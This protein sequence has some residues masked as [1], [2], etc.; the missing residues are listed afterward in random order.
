MK[1]NLFASILFVLL[2]LTTQAQDVNIP[3]A[4]FLKALISSGV[5]TNNDGKIQVSEASV[6]TALNIE[7]KF[8]AS[9]NGIE[10]FTA[11]TDL[12]CSRNPLSTLNLSKNSALTNLA[13]S[14]NYLS[15][16]D[17]SKNAALI[18]LDCSLN[19]LNSLDL[20]KNT[21][22]ELDCSYNQL[23]SLDISKNTAL[24]KLYCNN[25]QLST[26]DVNNNTLKRLKCSQNQLST[27]DIS[28]C[29]ALTLLDCYSNKLST[30]DVSKNGSLN[31]LDC[32][33]NQL[34]TLDVS[35]N[36]F[37]ILFG[38]FN[39]Q[40]STL[41]IN[42]NTKL[43]AMY[44]YNNPLKCISFLPKSIYSIKKDASLCLPNLP[45]STF[46]L[47]DE[48]NNFQPK[49]LCTEAYNS[50][51]Q[52]TSYPNIS[53]RIYID[54]NNDKQY[55]LGTDYPMP[56]AS[57][58]SIS[59][60]NTDIF[61][62]YGFKVDNLNQTYTIQPALPDGWLSTPIS[63]TVSFKTMGEV[64]E[65]KDF[66]V[67][68]PVLNDVW[69]EASPVTFARPG[70]V[71]KYQVKVKNLGGTVQTSTVQLNYPAYFTFI[72]SI[73]AGNNINTTHTWSAANLLP[74]EERIFTIEFTLSAET[75]LGT[76][77][78]STANIS[79]P[80][81]GNLANNV[82]EIKQTVRGSYDPNDK[83]LNKGNTVLRSAIQAQE[84]FVY[85]IRFQNTGTDTAFRVIIRDTLALN[86]FDLKS[87]QS[88][89]SSHPYTLKYEGNFLNW[90][91]NDIL[92]PDSITDKVGSNGF[93]KF[94]I[95]PLSTLAV[96]EEINNKAAIY[97]DFNKAVI[98][99][100]VN[101]RVSL[102]NSLSDNTTPTTQIFPNPGNGLFTV[103][104]VNDAYIQVLTATG[105]TIHTQNITDSGVLDLRSYAKGIYCLKIQ[106][107]NKTEMSKVVIELGD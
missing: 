31:F 39:N 38:C 99:N 104:G 56:N 97:F 76:E 29:N 64:S 25:N 46:T 10:A 71:V 12:N 96:D 92:L 80:N 74:F 28:N 93:V 49:I 103:K 3:D 18:S 4:N 59:E 26:L 47:S 33:A 53:G 2:C 62:K 101:T 88:L 107:A 85:T 50:T 19:Q 77:L 61:G 7:N 5:D 1:T 27:L 63:D 79:I 20:S 69:V 22:T 35:K 55:T 90:T 57:V 21:L 75:P 51:N 9:L 32:S 52:C 23:T 54:V 95:K 72:S 70:F 14:F 100:T 6:V 94:K 42:K 43:E 82:S 65:G 89:A 11:L 48:K 30:L 15:T 87:M 81:D 16:L 86:K 44:I 45:N 105:N 37:L 13:C 60:T 17:I 58:S 68:P 91:F 41:D 83:L 102:T 40:L 84:D 24:T 78:V 67:T 8:I 66:I 106:T 34:T 98:T 73:P 36:T